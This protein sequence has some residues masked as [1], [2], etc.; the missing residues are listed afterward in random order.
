MSTATT[1]GLICVRLYV[2]GVSS[3]VLSTYRGLRRH[4]FAR[5]DANLI[6][7]GMVIASGDGVVD[8]KT[9]ARS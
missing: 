8:I 4:G 5:R 2:T 1:Q 9:A 7:A 6:V 3:P